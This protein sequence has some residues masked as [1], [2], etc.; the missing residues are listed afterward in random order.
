MLRNLSFIVLVVVGTRC[1]Y[2]QDT[3]TQNKMDKNTN[4]VY[5]RTDTAKVSLPESDWQKVLTPEVFRVA[6]EKGT[7]RPGTSEFEKSKAVGTY[8]CKACGNALFISDTKFD[9]GCGW[10]S[11]YQAI[12]DS[13]V[14]YHRDKT[15]GMIRTEVVCG[16]CDAHLG[17]VF[18]DGPPPTHKRFCINGVVLDFEKK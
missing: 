1:S 13:S 17:H 8:Y 10:P 3:S 12:S 16:R 2:S 4:P 6:R 14:I 9:S 7:E 18:D 11:F 5:S 15:H